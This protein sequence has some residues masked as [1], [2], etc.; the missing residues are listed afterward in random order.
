MPSPMPESAI[1][2]DRL[3]LMFACAHPALATDAQ[4]ALTLRTLAGLS[5]AEIAHAFLVSKH[6]MGQRRHQPKPPAAAGRVD[7]PSPRAH[8]AHAR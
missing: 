2:D 7:P 3:A 1:P 5:T 8:L 6:T 4:V